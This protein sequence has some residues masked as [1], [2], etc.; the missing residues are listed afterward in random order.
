MGSPVLKLRHAVRWA[1]WPGEEETILYDCGSADVFL[2]DQASVALIA[3]LSDQISA[4]EEELLRGL[5]DARRQAR[6]GEALAQL[7]RLGLVVSTRSG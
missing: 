3:L 6:A 1:S 4:T 5:G 7:R 2:M